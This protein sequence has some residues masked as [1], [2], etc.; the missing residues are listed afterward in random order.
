M[1]DQALTPDELKALDRAGYTPC[2]GGIGRVD[3]GPYLKFRRNGETMHGS[4]AYWRGV[5]ADLPPVVDELAQP[6]AELAQALS[7]NARLRAAL[8]KIANRDDAEMVTARTLHYDMRGWAA[9]ALEA[10]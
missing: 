9:A 4:R 10:K 8:E 6:R 1:T 3:E 5:I 2:G 7:E